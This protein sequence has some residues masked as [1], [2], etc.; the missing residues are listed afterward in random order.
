MAAHGDPK[1][2][3]RYAPGGARLAHYERV[4]SSL[5][6]R[7][8]GD[9]G[10]A[11]LLHG[12]PDDL[13]E[14]VEAAI[15]PGA[16][17]ILRDYERLRAPFLSPDSIPG[18]G[19]RMIE[20]MLPE[21]RRPEA[22]ALL[23]CEQRDHLDPTG[24][25]T[26]WLV[27][28]HREPELVCELPPRGLVP[29]VREFSLHLEYA[30]VGLCPLAEELGLFFDRNRLDDLVLLH[31]DPDRARRIRQFVAD[32]AGP[33]G[34]A[35][36][37]AEKVRNLFLASE[38]ARE[39]ILSCNWEWRH[40][41][42]L[43]RVLGPD[44]TGWERQLRLCGFVTIK[45]SGKSAAYRA[46]GALHQLR[47]CDPS[48]FR[49]YISAKRISQY[50]AIHTAIAVPEIGVDGPFP[51]RL[52]AS[53]SAESRY[54]EV[55]PD[56]LGQ[57]RP[58]LGPQRSDADRFTAYTPAGEVKRLPHGAAVL[59]FALEVHRS[60]VCLVDHAV[61]AGEHRGL[62]DPVH[63][64]EAV[65]LVLLPQP[66]PLPKGWKKA[67]PQSTHAAIKAGARRAMHE[68]R[69]KQGLDWVA[70]KLQESGIEVARERIED[71]VAE[72]ARQAA[73]REKLISSKGSKGSPGG[74]W[75]RQI[76]ILQAHRQG[77]PTYTK[78][79]IQEHHLD[80]LLRTLCR[81]TGT[82]LD[83]DF[84]AELRLGT[85][86]FVDCARC[87]P[88]RDGPLAV[89]RS[90]KELRFHRA[91]A[92]CAAGA[93]E[94]RTVRWAVARHY[95][96]IEGS[97]RKGLFRDVLDDVRD[98]E[99][100]VID[101]VGRRFGRNWAVARL[102]LDCNDR[103][104]LDELVRH[105]Q[106]VRGVTRV[107]L[108]ERDPFLENGLPDR[109]EDNQLPGAGVRGN[110]YVRGGPV[111]RD[112]KF[113]GR[114]LEFHTLLGLLADV[115]QGGQMACIEGPLKVGKTSLAH[116]VLREVSRHADLWIPVYYT[117]PHGTSWS[118]RYRAPGVDLPPA[119]DAIAELLARSAAEAV[120]R[121]GLTSSVP[122]Y[123]SL[124]DL[125]KKLL[126]WPE[127][128]RIVLVID[129]AARLAL[130]SVEELSARKESNTG[131][132]KRIEEGQRDI[133]LAELELRPS[134]RPDADDLARFAQSVV[135]KPG[136][137]VI[138]VGPTPSFASIPSGLSLRHELYTSV[139][140]IPLGAF[141]IT[142][143]GLLLSAKKLRP[144][145]PIR[146]LD[147]TLQ[148]VH[149]LTGGDP[150][151]VGAIA[152]E[153]W[154]GRPEEG[155]LEYSPEMVARAADRVRRFGY[156]LDC[157]IG[158]FGP[159]RLL[160]QQL[161][162]GMVERPHRPTDRLDGVAPDLHRHLLDMLCMA[163]L[164]VVDEDEDHRLAA[165][166]MKKYLGAL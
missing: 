156:E 63:E 134:A 10:M 127:R 6:R 54:H 89:V 11:G 60:W 5:L 162:Q 95:V 28:M 62:L 144:A 123:D 77:E 140:R 75:L 32:Q 91:G 29:M 79:A 53:Q 65:D 4:A 48:A 116:R 57:I 69:H 122:E 166:L 43:S 80:V 146:F 76:G 145:S 84:D 3:E 90:G 13:P 103:R 121:R 56:D 142:E 85:E 87:V 81:I 112:E 163:G 27:A 113:Y 37:G 88:D 31:R 147:I 18:L 36:R 40:L 97:N 155:S 49:D 148:D 119:R 136:L 55:G 66:R 94:V 34:L 22:I 45:C 50:R 61:V 82:V 141:G 14:A 70:M 44:E 12:C 124:D 51:V 125:L 7:L 72:A 71:F 9:A 150:L 109:L 117:T 74:W 101:F 64:G 39:S 1:I 26:G 59:N 2:A 73:A 15:S 17:G 46:L 129:E 164:A 139:R 20:E 149:R 23:L 107:L 106:R 58:R 25:L 108:D 42:R 98:L 161:L 104:V 67:T 133:T 100:D 78:V 165:P 105:L 86:R 128:P 99:L 154:S 126:Q 153:L 96:L 158:Q 160:G 151:F 159:L 19:R 137:A 157:R 33:G 35:A 120:R 38:K 132:E 110:P 138:W 68:Q 30:E 92:P 52:L 111:Y 21:V 102:E 131:I 47:R 83:L 115:R 152:D 41:G 93:S 135:S 130:N 16:R 114:E 143:V 118:S 24:E 8:G